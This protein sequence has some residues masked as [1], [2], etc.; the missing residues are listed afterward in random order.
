MWTQIVFLHIIYTP[1]L[2]FSWLTDCRHS[3]LLMEKIY[4]VLVIGAGISGIA[5][6]K[7]LA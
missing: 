4:Q 5:A 6:A 3:Y 7:H 2:L 1:S